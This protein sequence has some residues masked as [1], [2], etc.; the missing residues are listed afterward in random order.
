MAFRE[1]SRRPKGKG[2]DTTGPG[3]TAEVI[4]GDE[5]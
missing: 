4:V 5:D 3:A 1:K 2:K